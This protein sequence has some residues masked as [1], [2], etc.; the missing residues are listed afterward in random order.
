MK[1][2]GWILCI[3]I[4]L[5]GLTLWDSTCRADGEL[6]V[7][8]ELSTTMVHPGDPFWFNGYLCNPGP[9]KTDVPVCFALEVFGEYWFWP[10]WTHYAPPDALGFDYHVFDVPVGETEVLV[11]SPFTWPDTGDT[12][13]TGLHFYGAMLDAGMNSILGELGIVEWGYSGS[14][15]KTREESIPE[16][17]VKMTPET[18]FWPPV[19]HSSEWSNPIPMPGLI[20]TAGVEDSAVIAADGN[21]FLFF[22]TPDG[23]V[24]AENQI[25]DG[26]T[27]VWWCTKN[28]TEWTEPV[29]A[30][31]ADTNGLHLDSPFS[32]QENTLWFGSIRTDN[33]GDIDIYT[34]VLSGG[35]WMNWQNA[36]EQINL[37]FD[38]GELYLTGDGNSLFFG[39][40]GGGFG[41]SDL[42][43]TTRNNQEWSAPVNLGTPVNSSGDESRPFISSDGSELWFT[44]M[45]SGKGYRGP[46]IFRTIKTGEIWSEPEEIVS[47]YVGDPG[48]DDN[49]NLYFTHLF[50][51]DAGNKIEADIYVSFRR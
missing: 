17:A 34:A 11:V 42:W 26:V 35:E 8:L 37:E 24:P 7:R 10:S 27:G 16:G 18:D 23:N 3:T 50:Y 43:L 48:L 46:A 19:I 33:L 31:L 21:T 29:R 4:I 25:L 6:G 40:V 13:V 39:K 51:D 36:G 49:G 44:K 20:N 38:V 12:E 9:S 30:Y 28:G 14:A 45:V 22:F 32:I 15:N 1:R 47:N 2:M 5:A 41:Q